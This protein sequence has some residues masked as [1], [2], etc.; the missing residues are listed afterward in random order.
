[1]NQNIL[2]IKIMAQFCY[3]G[4]SLDDDKVDSGCYLHIQSF[5]MKKRKEK[6]KFSIKRRNL[7][8]T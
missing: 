6:G 3:R 5:F 1:M 2:K 8:Y 7:A 4:E